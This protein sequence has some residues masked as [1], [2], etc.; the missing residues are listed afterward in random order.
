M[1]AEMVPVAH[2]LNDLLQRLEEAFHRERAF[3]ADAAH[4]L[5]TPLAG[6]RSVIEVALARPRTG[7]DY[8]QA[9]TECLDIVLHTQSM[10]DNLLALARLDSGQLTLRPETLCLSEVV[11]AAW[12]PLADKTVARGLSVDSRVPTDLSFKTDR[13]NLALTLTVLLTNAVEYSDDDGQIRIAAQQLGDLV[14]LTVANSG[15]KLSEDAA[16]HVFERFW[17]ADASRTNTGIHCGLGLAIAKRIVTSL[18]GTI[19]A[20]V[21]G[22]NFVVRIIL[23]ASPA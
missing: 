21:S 11:D 16:R 23:P 2:R 12:R 13:D 6:L 20:S 5:R 15:C 17:R 19:A 3:T 18:G 10:I 9:M 22:D 1:P 7:D 4:E 14:E 8:E